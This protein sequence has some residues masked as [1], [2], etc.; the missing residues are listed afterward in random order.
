MHQN[1]QQMISL[2]KYG[3]C[4]K[5]V[6]H[7]FDKIKRIISLTIEDILILSGLAVIVTA[8][9]LLSFVAGLYCTG[10]VLLG[11]GI[12]AAVKESREGR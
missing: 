10:S 3:E 5:N 1:T 7:I 4:E 11:L 6:K 12:Y 9:F 8:T 2:Q